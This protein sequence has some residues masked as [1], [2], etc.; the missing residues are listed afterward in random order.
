MPEHCGILNKSKML[1]NVQKACGCKIGSAGTV[2]D[3]YDY[4]MALQNF[5]ITFWVVNFLSCNI[6]IPCQPGQIN[7]GRVVFIV[8]QT[9]Q[10]LKQKK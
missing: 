8:F 5:L 7:G 2:T 6:V 10:F 1:G 9:E 3:Q 4:C